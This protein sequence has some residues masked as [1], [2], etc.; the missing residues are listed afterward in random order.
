MMFFFNVIY[1]CYLVHL[2]GKIAVTG[3]FESLPRSY[4]E[5]VFAFMAR[6]ELF[7]EN[8]L[9]RCGET[10]AVICYIVLNSD[11]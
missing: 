6:S 5:A 8:L 11:K 1:E 4:F 10:N 2:N 9:A 3:N 7:V